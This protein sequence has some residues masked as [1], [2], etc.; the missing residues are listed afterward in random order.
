MELERKKTK[1]A[2]E[3]VIRQFTCERD[4]LNESIDL[5]GRLQRNEPPER[6]AR[7][8]PVTRAGLKGQGVNRKGAKGREAE[9]EIYTGRS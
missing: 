7:W 8:G 3:V 6:P 4:R 5:L 1:S 9:G 2:L